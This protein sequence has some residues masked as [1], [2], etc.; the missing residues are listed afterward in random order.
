M[1]YN[2]LFISVLFEFAIL[3]ADIFS[4]GIKSSLCVFGFYDPLIAGE[5]YCGL[6]IDLTEYYA[7]DAVFVGGETQ[8]G[9]F[10]TVVMPLCPT[11]AEQGNEYDRYANPA[12]S[13]GGCDTG[14]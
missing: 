11:N 4:K 7:V 9:V 8:V 13:I 6:R 10:V 2:C 5:D 1:S 3:F 12:Q 14:G